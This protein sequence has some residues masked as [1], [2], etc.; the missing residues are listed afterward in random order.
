MI[1]IDGGQDNVELFDGQ[2]ED[3]VVCEEQATKAKA[4]TA[5]Q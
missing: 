1:S 5:E 2:T 4:A 3:S